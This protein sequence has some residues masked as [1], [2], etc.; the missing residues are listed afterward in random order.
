M[1]VFPRPPFHSFTT[2]MLVHAVASGVS[3]HARIAALLR[4]CIVLDE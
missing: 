3:K 1:S 2:L 4:G